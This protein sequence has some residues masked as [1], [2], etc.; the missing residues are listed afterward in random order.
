EK[1]S[2]LQIVLKIYNNINES[3]G[4]KDALHSV[5]EAR[6]AKLHQKMLDTVQRIGYPSQILHHAQITKRTL[7]QIDNLISAASKPSASRFMEAWL[8]LS[9]ADFTRS[10]KTERR[11]ILEFLRDAC[12][13][14]RLW[15]V[16]A[17]SFKAVDALANVGK[18]VEPSDH[19]LVNE[20]LSLLA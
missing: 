6:Y 13:Q 8:L 18:L 7:R 5:R 4:L 14:D 1:D 19:A 16:T 15:E 11:Q 20:V 17:V 2:A 10:S 12:G 9:T 3:L